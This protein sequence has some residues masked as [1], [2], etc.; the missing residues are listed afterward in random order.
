LKGIENHKN[1]HSAMRNS[2]IFRSAAGYWLLAGGP[3][4]L[5]SW[6]LAAAV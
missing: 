1:G 3:E 2:H 4:A 5:G 6:Q